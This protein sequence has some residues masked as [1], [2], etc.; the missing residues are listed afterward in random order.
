MQFGQRGGSQRQP[1]CKK[2]HLK[3]VI[4]IDRGK[5]PRPNP[6]DVYER[7]GFLGRFRRRVP[8]KIMGYAKG[9]V[10]TVSTVPFFP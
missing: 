2:S 10:L 9:D 3:A 5:G 8:R 6:L 4:V 1:R 7:R